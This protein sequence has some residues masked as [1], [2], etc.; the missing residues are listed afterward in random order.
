MP[1]GCIK[2]YNSMQVKQYFDVLTNDYA[3]TYSYD[4][5]VTI[6]ALP[7]ILTNQMTG[8]YIYINTVYCI[9]FVYVVIART[10]A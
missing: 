8:I 3:K 5:R 4:V 6:R 1:T 9:S 7:A 10:S 2:R